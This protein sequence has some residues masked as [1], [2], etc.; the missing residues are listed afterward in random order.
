MIDGIIGDS[1]LTF[2]E[3]KSPTLQEASERNH[4]HN[5][6]T[7]D[8]GD[9]RLH[10]SVRDAKSTRASCDTPSIAQVADR[11]SD[12]PFSDPV[13]TETNKSDASSTEGPLNHE[14]E[15]SG[16]KAEAKCTQDDAIVQILITSEIKNTK[17]L[18]VH[19]K[20]S[21]YLRDVRLA[22]C[23]RQEK[24][25]GLARSVFLT[26]KGRRLFDVT[27]CKSLGVRAGDNNFVESG[28]LEDI[29]ANTRI[30]LEAA[31]EDT[32]QAQSPGALSPTGSADS[33]SSSSDDRAM[34][35]HGETIRVVLRCPGV[36]TIEV[37][38]RT[39]TPISWLVDKFRKAHQIPRDQLIFLMFDGDR[40]DPGLSIA[41]YDI[42]ESDMMDVVI[43]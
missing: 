6:S 10:V 8:P 5:G 13:P 35:N 20:M 23:R 34:E 27:T 16:N 9:T 28:D 12:P 30:H 40:L 29:G 1:D 21:Q 2:V 43:K 22:W 18:I 41:D 11:E 17:P 14:F 36:G 37:H 33:Y 19:R 42:A 3:S 38:P 15:G 25:E 31:T 24:V 32:F 26:W 7:I 39:K 4:E